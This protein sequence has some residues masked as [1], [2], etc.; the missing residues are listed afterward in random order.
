[1][2]WNGAMV[3]SIYTTIPSFI[4]FFLTQKYFIKGL[5][6]GALKGK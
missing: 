2:D 3:T 1:M 6:A 5:T 4:F